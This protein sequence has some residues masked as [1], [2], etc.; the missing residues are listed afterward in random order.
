MLESSLW[1]VVLHPYARSTGSLFRASPPSH[2]HRNAL[3]LWSNLGFPAMV[4]K[5]RLAS[6]EFALAKEDVMRLENI[7]SHQKFHSILSPEILRTTG[8]AGTFIRLAGRKLFQH[9]IPLISSSLQQ[10]VAASPPSSH[11]ESF[12]F[13][14]TEKSVTILYCRRYW[15]LRSRAEAESSHTGAIPLYNGEMGSLR[16]RVKQWYAF[17]SVCND[18]LKLS[19]MPW[20]GDEQPSLPSNDPS[21]A[22]MKPLNLKETQCETLWDRSD[23]GLGPWH[24]RH[25]LFCNA[26][27]HLAIQLSCPPEESVRCM[28][29]SRSLAKDTAVAGTEIQLFIAS[30]QLRDVQTGSIQLLGRLICIVTTMDAISVQVQRD[31]NNDMRIC[32]F[33]LM[34]SGIMIIEEEEKEIS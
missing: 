14:R 34:Q 2:V 13:S 3:C 18:A 16:A 26:I 29:G 28:C 20:F 27:L 32:V 7:R 23:L 33:S 31:G 30:S 12:C 11:P 21:L 17:V 1:L 6:F 8:A 10:V 19:R 22:I 15:L 5:D 25:W 9:T 24:S 4:A